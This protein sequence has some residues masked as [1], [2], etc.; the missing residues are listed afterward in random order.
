MSRLPLVS[1]FILFAAQLV[2]ATP[3]T[4][5]WFTDLS[6]QYARIYTDAETEAANLAVTTWEHPTGNSQLTPTYS[7][8]HEISVT[9]TNL[10]IRTSGLGFHVMGPWL[11][12]RGGIFNNYPGNIVRVARFPLNP[13]VGEIPRTITGG[14]PVGYLVDGVSMFDSRDA[15]S[16][17]ND[18]GLDA[19][20]GGIREDGPGDG[21]W[22]RNAFVTEINTFDVSNAHPLTELLHHHAQPKGLRHLLGDSLSYD[23][24]T[25]TYTEAPN[26]QH[27][28]ILGWNFDGF[29]IYGPYG[30]SHP[31]D[32]ES[33]VRRMVT[34]FQLRDGSNGSTDLAATGRTTIPDWITRNEP[35]VRTNPLVATQ[36]GPDVDSTAANE[37]FILSHYIEDQ[38]YKG[39]LTGL[40][41]YD[42]NV[43]A[44]RGFNPATDFDLN[45]YNVRWG[46]TPEF[47]E[48]TWAYF[49]CIDEAGVSTFPFVMSRYHFGV[50]SGNDDGTLPANR[51]I[52][53]EGGPEATQS[54]SEFSIDD[55]SGDVTLT[56]SGI[57]GGTYRIEHSADLQQWDVLNENAQTD[58]GIFGNEIDAARALTDN[59]QFYRSALTGIAPFDD[60]GFD[61]EPLPVPTF[62]ATFSPLPP[63]DQIT[64]VTVGGVPAT[65]LGSL[66]STLLLDFDPS[67]LAAGDYPAIITYTPAGGSPTQLSSSETFTVTADNN[68]LLVIVDDWGIDSS[69][70]DN[71]GN[72]SASLPPMP[73]L[74][75]LAANGLRFTNAYAQPVCAPTRASIITGRHGFRN[76]VGHPT[77]SGV[78]STSELT[79]PEIF[80]AESSPYS[81]ACI[82]K[83]H[84]GGGAGG[85]LDGPSTIGGWPEFRGYF[86]NIGNYFDW[87]KVVNGTVTNNVTTYATTEQVN[88]TIDFIGTQTSPWFVWLAF[89]AP[90][91][92]YHNPPADLHDYP[93]FPTN[94]AGTVTGSDQRGAYEASLQAFDTELGRL[95][96]TVDLTTTNVILIGD[97]G[98]PGNVI[99]NPYS[100]PHSKDTLYEGGVRVPLLAIGP[101]IPLQGT[102]DE[103]VHC[104]DLFSTILELA[105]INVAAATSGVDVIDSQSLVPI[106]SSTDTAERCIVAERHTT[107][108]NPEGTGR[109]LRLDSHPDYKLI[110]FGD[111]T[112]A[113]DISTYEMYQIVTDPNEQTP[114]T[115]PAVVSDPHFDAYQALIAKDAAVGPVAPPSSIF[116]ELPTTPTGSQAVPGQTGTAPISIII[117]GVAATFIARVDQSGAAQRYW[118]QCSLPD[119]SGAPYTEAIV[120][121]PP[122]DNAN[123]GDR[124][125]TAIQIIESP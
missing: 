73:N 25:N 15:L 125:F 66:G 58:S 99:Q 3:I 41:L 16:F 26:G 19:T 114:L 52:I 109:S 113:T 50:V 88:D 32:P 29:P 23:V 123:Q 31:Q 112:S 4:S 82:G 111:P 17:R 10:Y 95:L 119:D 60:R 63:L 108:Q 34:G 100:D 47:P 51:E 40:T 30:Y 96:E 14:G 105:D 39:D 33:G 22:N 118:V 83:W 92:P 45:E 65:I 94:A 117:D 37:T 2:V 18:V 103:I 64:S 49:I 12:G 5:T 86:T 28:P 9:N 116:L 46:V 78:L 93:V 79:L 101:D 7:G 55:A 72:P 8:V 80:A 120:T 21:V 84:L 91:S 44:T 6:G 62:T 77:G 71:I 24:V 69:P 43:A 98:T 11:G 36:Y 48:G 110:V 115:L 57:E 102:S 81:V 20:P 1:L 13:V 106:F 76:G 53:F 38:A 70:I 68:I 54:S 124:I 61:Y 87:D 74:E 89:T 35:G 67:G 107:T 56:W 90:H 97:N 85:N 122:N 42:E 59:R 27:S 75:L 121:F 104:V